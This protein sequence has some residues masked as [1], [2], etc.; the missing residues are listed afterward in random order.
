MKKLSLSHSQPNILNDRRILEIV[1][2]LFPLA[3][4]DPRGDLILGVGEHRLTRVDTSPVKRYFAFVVTKRDETKGA[5][6]RNPNSSVEPDG[7]RLPGRNTISSGTATKRISPGPGHGDR[8]K[9]DEEKNESNESFS[10]VPL[11]LLPSP[12]PP[13]RQTVSS[14]YA[15]HNRSKTF[16]HAA[17]DKLALFTLCLCRRFNDTLLPLRFV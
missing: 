2:S 17:L 7:T 16:C 10:T 11:S 5:S 3:S 1:P 13:A 4:I 6:E 15:A 9:E 12:V 14:S 8:M